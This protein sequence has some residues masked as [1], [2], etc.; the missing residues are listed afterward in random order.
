MPPD[1]Q[2]STDVAGI[3]KE[4]TVLWKEAGDSEGAAP[5]VR[6]CS[7]NLIV[8]GGDDPAAV[9][10]LDLLST[11]HPARTFLIST[12][13][14]QGAK[15]IESWVAAKCTIPLPGE[16]QVCSE[17]IHLKAGGGAAG[18]IPS[19]VTSLLVP[20]IPV[21]LWYRGTDE[22]PQEVFNVL[23]QLS[24]FTIL[25]SG[26]DGDLHRSILLLRSVDDARFGDMAWERGES[27][28][29]LLAQLFDPPS[30]RK[31][32][33]G[34]TSIRITCAEQGQAGFPSAML[35]AGWLCHTLDLRGDRAL[36]KGSNGSFG[37][38]LTQN[39]SMVRL[40]ISPEPAGHSADS[41][42]RS[43]VLGFGNSSLSL[44][45]KEEESCFR[46]IW[47]NMDGSAQ[48]AS[49]PRRG[50]SDAEMVSRLLTFLDA[51][52]VYRLSLAALAGRL[53]A[54]S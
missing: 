6:A 1:E 48:E 11:E 53:L 38:N 14:D 10:I 31:L 47:T 33:G 17:Q 24:D 54:A 49:I 34:L 20:D 42:I 9:E 40:D 41:P 26:E 50:V 28:R 15:T 8:L 29:A 36:R 30:E 21:V 25:D 23:Q 46:S 19:M 37:G 22:I 35:F 13:G 7:L 45:V 16:K 5:V 27:W 39:G 4:L 12:T 3:E 43:L 51:E 32:L 44:S 2:L 18:R 52:P